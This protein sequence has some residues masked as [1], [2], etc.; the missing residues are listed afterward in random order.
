LCPDIP[1]PAWL[2]FALG[3]GMGSSRIILLPDDEFWNLYLPLCKPIEAPSPALEQEVYS[4]LN[5]LDGILRPAL[6]ARWGKTDAYWEVMDDW[7]VCYHHSM[8]VHS[9]EMCCAEL[10]DIVQG[11]LGQ[12]KHD[13]CF[14]VSLECI[15]DMGWGPQ[16][17]GFGQ[18]VFYQGK[19]YGDRER[20]F[21]YALFDA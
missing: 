10:L 7:N 20:E 15:E 16:H 21:K 6:D 8:S 12:M 2:R 1:G 3:S 19:V 13:W 14:H 4:E 5:A 17:A 9:D 18:I 11:A